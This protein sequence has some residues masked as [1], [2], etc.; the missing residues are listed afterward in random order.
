VVAWPQGEVLQVTERRP[1]WP[2]GQ[3][4]CSVLAQA[5]SAR[6]IRVVRKPTGFCSQ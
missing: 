3:T 1:D 2:Q 6:K 4:E 5:L